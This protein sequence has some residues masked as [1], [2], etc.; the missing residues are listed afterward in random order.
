[1]RGSCARDGNALALTAGELVGEPVANTLEP[2][3]GKHLVR[4][5]GGGA[6][7]L[8]GIAHRAPWIER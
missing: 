4:A 2:D 7:F 5:G 8:D 3:L 1:M 6:C